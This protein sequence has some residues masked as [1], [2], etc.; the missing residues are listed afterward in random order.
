MARPSDPARLLR[1]RC[2]EATRAAMARIAW[3]DWEHARLG[4]AL[5]DFRR[6]DLEGFVAR[7]G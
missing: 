3:W 4:A 2:G 5:E 6:L 7:H 1:F